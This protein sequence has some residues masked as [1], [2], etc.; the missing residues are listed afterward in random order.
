MHWLATHVGDIGG[1]KTAVFGLVSQ[2]GDDNVFLIIQAGRYWIFGPVMRRTWQQQEHN[3]DDEQQQH[4]KIASDAIPWSRGRQL[5]RF[6]SYRVR[7]VF[8]VVGRLPATVAPIGRWGIAIG[9]GNNGA[10]FFAFHG[11]DL[12]MD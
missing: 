8:A 5:R 7:G 6:F 1:R 2:K 4:K 10:A 3:Y 11:H 9:R 12:R